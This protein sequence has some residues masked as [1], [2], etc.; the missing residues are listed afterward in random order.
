M[1]LH[2]II[3]A[4]IAVIFLAIA[5]IAA[6]LKSK[7]KT[8]TGEI[9]YK[10]RGALLSPA[11][12][13]FFR[14]LQNVIGKSVLICPKVRLVDILK[15]NNQAASNKI[16]QKHVDFLLCNPATTRVLGVVELDDKSHGRADRVERDA[17]VDG[18]F[19]AAGIRIVH[20]KA[21]VSYSVEEVRQQLKFIS[22]S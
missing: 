4:A 7:G 18:A 19:A 2:L 9:L 15:P 11:E 17:F 8:P 12:L 10:T 20:F 1:T 13:S 5:I 16:S 14:I 3:G 21:S 6:I 22:E